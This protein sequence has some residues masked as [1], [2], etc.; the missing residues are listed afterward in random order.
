MCA[1]SCISSGVSSGR[2]TPYDRCVESCGSAPTAMRD[3]LNLKYTARVVQ[4][5]ADDGERLDAE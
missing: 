3:G 1:I 2:G 4:L 5:G